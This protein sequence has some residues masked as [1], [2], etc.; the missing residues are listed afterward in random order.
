MVFGKK[1][2]VVE[3]NPNDA[4]EQTRDADGEAEA[5]ESAD[6]EA[7]HQDAAAP[8]ADG[9]AGE[10]EEMRDK[11]LRALAELENYKKRALRERSELLK[12]QGERI[13]FDIVELAD[14]MEIAL[15]QQGGTLEQMREGFELTNKKLHEILSRWDVR[16][17]SALGKAFDPY[18]H[19]ALSQV[20]TPNSEPGTVLN[21]MRKTF[22]Y[23]DKLLR[24]G[25]VVVSAA[26]PAQSA[27]K[28]SESDEQ[29]EVQ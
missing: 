26:A 21:E 14:I 2:K 3:E 27:D 6:T 13:L 28:P 23:K 16:C 12:Y 19:R 24:A 29:K 22:F 10:L 18:K 8:S 7:V 25:E 20:P 1:K 5:V 4:Q 15:A 9:A 11:Y 17:E